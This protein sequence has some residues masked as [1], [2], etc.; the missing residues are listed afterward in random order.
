MQKQ[1]LIFL[2]VGMGFALLAVLMVKSYINQQHQAIQ[3]EAE[4]M[5]KALTQMQANQ[6]AVLVAKRDIPSGKVIEA[7][8]LESVIIPNQYLQPQVATSLDRISGMMTIAPV[9]KGEQLTLSKLVY[10]TKQQAA[11]G[12]GLAEV[13][14]VG[15]R[16]ITI[17]VDNIS[18]LAGMINPGNY[19]DVITVIPLPVQTSEGKQVKQDVVIPIFQNVQVLAVGQEIGVLSP[20]VTETRYKKEEKKEPSPLITL[21]LS[22]TE[23][24][25]IAFVQEQGKI[26]LFLRSPIDSQIQPAQA[27]NWDT[28]FQYIMPKETPKIEKTPAEEEVTYVEI[29]RGLNKEKAPLS[30]ILKK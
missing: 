13:T 30:G 29:Y 1:R 6:T 10:P 20:Q 17:S 2:I 24:N 28:L 27:A 5:K 8:M 15:K 9:A 16:A 26:R 25:L 18:G 22:P 23:A 19:V 21:A 14:P 11:G 4:K 7:E 3:S 12:K